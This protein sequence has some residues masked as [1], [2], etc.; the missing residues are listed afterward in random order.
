MS[1]NLPNPEKIRI[2]VGVPGYGHV[3]SLCLVSFGSFVAQG[4]GRGYINNIATSVGAYIDR[5]RN[6]I[7]KQALSNGS[8]HLMFVDQDMVLPDTAMLRLLS[9]NQAVSG[10]LYFGKDDLY[11]PVA[12]D[13]DPFRRVYNLEDDPSLYRPA[14]RSDE[15]AELACA[16][17]KTDDHIHRVG[18]VGMGCTLIKTSLFRRMKKHFGD[19]LWFSSK[20]CGEDVHF[21]LRCKELGV[22]IYLDGFIQCGHVRDEMITV[23]HYQWAREQKG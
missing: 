14:W 20:E 15:D 18:G 8:T 23:R 22:P 9:H 4:V 12:F 11:T 19:E 10:G 21:A 5:G 7:V 16:C 13:F 17:G 2:T 3:P 6:E 1:F